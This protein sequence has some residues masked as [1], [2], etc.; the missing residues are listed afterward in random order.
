M[1]PFSIRFYLVFL[2][3]VF[4]NPLSH[5]QSDTGYFASDGEFMRKVD[6]GSFPMGATEKEK[7][8]LYNSLPRHT[9]TLSGYYI[10]TT[11]VS[12][13]NFKLFIDETGYKTVAEII[14]SSYIK[15]DHDFSF[16]KGITW[17]N[18]EWGYLRDSLFNDFPVF[19][20]SWYDAVEYC[21][22]LSRRE[23]LSPVYTI[24]R[25]T[26]DTNN[27]SEYDRLKWKVDWND[28]LPNHGYRLPTEAEWE[29][30]ARGGNLSK[31]Y[32]YSGSDEIS[33]V[34]VS[35]KGHLVYKG[36]YPIAD[37]TPNELG[38]Y[39]MSFNVMEWCWDWFADY[40]PEP[41]TNPKGASSAVWRVKRG[42]AWY[43]LGFEGNPAFRNGYSADTT[44]FCQG[45]RIARN[46]VK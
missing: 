39:N 18:N 26:I 30:A 6:G 20:V 38:I 7:N 23:G 25:T 19:H 35:K 14:D 11:E 8:L 10:S 16:T 27:K 36:S 28:N 43:G 37:N 17:R 42:G 1:N 9:V 40:T 46:F 12:L 22:W 29:F 32:F 21:N 31:G 3:V 4:L 2:T 33:E 24:D 45:F 5:A 44:F 13:G 41:K 15:D 34:A